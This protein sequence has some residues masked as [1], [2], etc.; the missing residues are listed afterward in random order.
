MIRDLD[1]SHTWT[2]ETGRECQESKIDGGYHKGSHPVWNKGRRGR[3]E[4]EGEEKKQKGIRGMGKGR[5]R[6]ECGG[7]KGKEKRPRR[8]GREDM[9]EKERRKG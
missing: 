5:E 7:R 3:E 2:A 4:G 8:R 9:E 1:K 6:A